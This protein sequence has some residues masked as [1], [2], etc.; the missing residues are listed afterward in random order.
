MIPHSFT[1]LP[2]FF[3]TVWCYEARQNNFLMKLPPIKVY[4][5][6]ILIFHVIKSPDDCNKL[7]SD[8]GSVQS[9]STANFM[10]SNISKTRVISF[11]RKANTFNYDYKL[12]QLY[13]TYTDSI[14]NIY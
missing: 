7:Q 3:L 6:Q 9:W 5:Y 1:V 14:G 2:N 8:I 10:K 11:L 4:Y 12:C 13:V